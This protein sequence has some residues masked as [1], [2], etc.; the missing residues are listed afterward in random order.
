MANLRNEFEFRSALLTALGQEHTEAEAKNEDTW[1][2]KML[3]GLGVEYDQNDV[4]QFGLFREK[5]IEGVTNYS[6]GGGE[7]WNTVFEGNVTTVYS[8][9]THLYGA[10]L[11]GVSSITGDSIRVTLNGV[12]YI[13]PKTENGY[14]AE[15]ESGIDFDTYPLFI[16]TADTPYFLHT[17]NANT[18]SLKIEEPQSGGGESDFT[19][20][21]VTME[22]SGVGRDAKFGITFADTDG[23]ATALMVEA[24]EMPTGESRTFLID[25]LEETVRYG[26]PITKEIYLYQNN[27]LLV[28]TTSVNKLED[29]TITGNAE[30]ISME[31]DGV[32]QWFVK[33]YGNCTI[34][35]LGNK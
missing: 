24:V 26:S 35:V 15:N 12:E 6:G 18:Y 5:L 27:Y 23:Q 13:L 17:P 7:T 16:Y 8:E 4:N 14:G 9:E 20:V 10:E 31:L 25:Y 21:N 2:R 11:N 1:R 34:S 33:V 19:K 32:V 28:S 22:V 29:F 3:D 30:V